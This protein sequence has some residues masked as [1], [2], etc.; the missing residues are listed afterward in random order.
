MS[1]MSSFMSFWIHSDN[2]LFVGINYN[3]DSKQHTCHIETYAGGK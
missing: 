1:F 3:R 2:L